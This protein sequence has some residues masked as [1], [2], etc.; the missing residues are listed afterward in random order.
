MLPPVYLLILLVVVF[1]ATQS[2]RRKQQM[3]GGTQRALIGLIG[4]AFVFVCVVTAIVARHA[5]R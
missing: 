5:P 4:L 2:M 1:F 3:S